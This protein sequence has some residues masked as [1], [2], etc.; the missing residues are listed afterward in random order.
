MTADAAEHLTAALLANR[1]PRAYP[2]EQVFRRTS[3]T[4]IVAGQ[5]VVE[6][7]MKRTWIGVIGLATILAWVNL[8]ASQEKPK[9]PAQPKLPESV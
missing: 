5:P 4:M 6:E 2:G 7:K 8:A 3:S 1:L 9:Q